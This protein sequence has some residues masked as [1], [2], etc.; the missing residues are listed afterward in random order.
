MLPLAALRHMTRLV[1]GAKF[2][3]AGP[4]RGRAA[5]S[6]SHHAGGTPLDTTF[7]RML[8]GLMPQVHGSLRVLAL[9]GPLEAALRHEVVQSARFRGLLV[10]LERWSHMRA[11]QAPGGKTDA[12]GSSVAEAEGPRADVVH[13]V[14]PQPFGPAP[15]NPTQWDT[16]PYDCPSDDD[17]YGA[18]VPA[19]LDVTAQPLATLSDDLEA[20]SD[21]EGSVGVGADDDAGGGGADGADEDD[22]AGSAGGGVEAAD[23]ED[24]EEYHFG[25]FYDPFT[26]RMVR[27][28]S[29]PRPPPPTAVWRW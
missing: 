3:A 5:S 18:N 8:A 1:I 11:A 6:S 4:A 28:S 17:E 13:A 24:D 2:F 15:V 19:W 7:K 20:M 16:W 22:D 29:A 27:V 12:S 26:G 10:G 25:H 21:G 14:L 23:D 9:L